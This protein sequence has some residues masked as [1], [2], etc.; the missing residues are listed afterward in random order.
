MTKRAKTLAVVDLGSNAVRLG[1]QVFRTGRLSAE[2]ITACAVALERFAG[3]AQRAGADTV[4]AVATSAVREAS[5]RKQ[6]LDAVR[7]RSGLE[8]EVISGAEEARLVCL[9][10][11]Q[12]APDS[13]RALLIDI[14]G[15]STEI[16]AARGEEPEQAVSL[17]LGSVRL[18]EFFV[19]HDPVARKEA[20]LV[21][22]A[23]ADA[24][25]EIESVL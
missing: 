15:G 12:G 14:G 6:L 20:R 9:G 3:L 25:A 11:Q 7:T 4:R 2:S 19:K 5:N 21:E 24:V 10:V 22:E 8:V 18:T 17:Q 1:A 23:V 16:I 13:E